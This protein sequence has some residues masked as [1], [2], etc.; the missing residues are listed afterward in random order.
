MKILIV[1]GTILMDHSKVFNCLHQ[2]FIL[3]N[4]NIFELRSVL[5]QTRFGKGKTML[6]VYELLLKLSSNLRLMKLAN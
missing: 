5:V 4:C 2:D 1:V 6:D 3:F